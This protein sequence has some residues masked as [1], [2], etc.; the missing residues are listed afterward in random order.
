VT[1]GGATT[2]GTVTAAG[3]PITA[4]VPILIINANFAGNFNLPAVNLLVSGAVVLTL[5]ANSV[6]NSVALAG[7]STVNL[8]GHT[9]TINSGAILT[10]SGT[11][12][13]QDTVG[14]GALLFQNTVPA[15]VEGIIQQ[16]SGTTL[17]IG[18]A[19]SNT[20]PI[21]AGNNLTL[22]ADTLNFNGT[23]AVNSTYTGTTF[24][25]TGNVFLNVGATA[26]VIPTPLIIG[27]GQ[28]ASRVAVN[29]NFQQLSGPGG[30]DNVTV[31]DTG[32]LQIIA[33]N[34]QTVGTLTLKSGLGGALVQIGTGGAATLSVA[35]GITS[36]TVALSPTA[37]LPGNAI[38]TVSNYL[39]SLIQ[40]TGALQLPASGTFTINV[41]KTPAI[42]NAGVNNGA[43]G[44]VDLLIIPPLNGG[45]ALLDKTGT[46][47]L[48][49]SN[50]PTNFGGSL[51]IDGGTFA[52][53][54]F[55]PSPAGFT[56]NIVVNAGGILGNAHSTT[57]TLTTG[58]ITVNGGQI[59]PGLPPSPLT[60]ANSNADYLNQ[61]TPV[62]PNFSAGGILNL[63]VD[64]YG[65]TTDWDQFQA[66]TGAGNQ[67]TLGGTSLLNLD[68]LGL[69][70]WGTLTGNMVNG[71]GASPFIWSNALIGRF[72]NAPNATGNILPAADVFNNPTGF[73]AIVSY[74]KG[75]LTIVLTHPPTVPSSAYTTGQNTPLIVS[76]KAAGVLAGLTDPDFVGAVAQATLDTVRNPGTYTG[77]AGGT[78]AVNA[79]GTFIYTPATDFSGTETFTLTAVN[80]SGGS[81][82]FTVS[83]IVTPGTAQVLPVV[84][85]FRVRAPRGQVGIAGF[86]FDGDGIPEPHLLV[87]D[88]LDGTRTF[89]LLQP[90]SGF[91]FWPSQFHKKHLHRHQQIATVSVVDQQVLAAGGGFIPHF[92]VQI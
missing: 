76:T 84:A 42:S 22:A 17:N 31:N 23:T 88:W 72:S 79:D 30:P 33:A 49:L 55:P 27:E 50:N 57:N 16:A 52:S 85:A 3:Q 75:F 70:E 89:L 91:S 28:V 81:T 59:N 78:L 35:N 47:V 44:E 40:G 64:A 11:D 39:L 86:V 4:A 10:E 13:I 90:A 60:P 46:G 37:G 77:P 2:F 61:G 18:T 45:N 69:A 6:I 66:T 92:D 20:V 36:G 62:T 43:G 54:V 63:H 80:P 74:G 82:A 67:V 41:G 15:A 51:Q 5:N 26:N 53:N 83:F 32:E 9:L 29:S 21:T 56:P 14:G 65:T 8:N 87:I 58:G 7:G 19:G 73:Q 34:S 25:N 68:L 12:N 71:V 48:V 24:V 1:T 38:P